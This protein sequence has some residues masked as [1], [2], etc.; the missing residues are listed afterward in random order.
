MTR[1]PVLRRFGLE[2]L[3]V[4][5]DLE[6]VRS[7]V[8]DVAELDE[9]RRAGFPVARWILDARCHG[10]L[11]PR[12]E[13]AMEVADRDDALR[14]RGPGDSAE[15][16]AGEHERRRSENAMNQPRP[17]PQ[18]ARKC[19]TW[20]EARQWP[21]LAGAGFRLKSLLASMIYSA[22]KGHVAPAKEISWPIGK[23]RE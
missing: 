13:I 16:E 5:D 2:L 15:R 3:Q 19:V 9:G 10:D 22:S 11:G 14:C 6:R 7:A 21:R 17:P 4:A 8:G 12:L 18:S 20:H 23:T 1:P